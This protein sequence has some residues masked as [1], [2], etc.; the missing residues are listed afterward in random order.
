MCLQSSVLLRKKAKAPIL[1]YYEPNTIFIL[2]FIYAFSHA[3]LLK[4]CIVEICRELL[5]TTYIMALRWQYIPIWICWY[6]KYNVAFAYSSQFSS[7]EKRGKWFKMTGNWTKFFIPHILNN[8]K[9]AL[10]IG[11]IFI[12]SI[13]YQVLALLYFVN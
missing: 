3:R 12:E 7:L 10:S 13:W 1:V 8:G 4:L 11:V 2:R 6:I 5:P 9:E